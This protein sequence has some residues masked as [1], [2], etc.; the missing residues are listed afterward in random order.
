MIAR[1]LAYAILSGNYGWQV[2]DVDVAEECQ[3]RSL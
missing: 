1:S 3:D 2:R